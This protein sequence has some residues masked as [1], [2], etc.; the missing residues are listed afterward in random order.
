MRVL[1]SNL[2]SADEIGTVY[3]AF[4]VLEGVGDLAGLP[5]L[6]YIYSATLSS[7][8]GLTFI[9]VAG[10]FFLALLTSFLLRGDDMHVKRTNE[11]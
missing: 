6:S 1:I 9:V 11:V 4:S 8:A 5:V 3:A 2:V 10:I 7:F